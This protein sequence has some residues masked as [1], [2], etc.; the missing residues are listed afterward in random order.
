MEPK[1][2][3]C[4]AKPYAADVSCITGATSMQDTRRHDAFTTISISII[5]IVVADLSH[6][7]LGHGVATHLQGAKL[8]V[9]SYTHLTSDLQSRL[10]SAAGPLVNL[11]EGLVAPWGYPPG[12]GRGRTHTLRHAHTGWRA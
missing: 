12:N 2:S 5:A 3:L 11:I 8:I 10:I 4:R 1:A 7:A 6:E 9:L